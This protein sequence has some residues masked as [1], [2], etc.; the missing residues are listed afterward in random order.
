MLELA[1]V[2]ERAHVSLDLIY[3]LAMLTNFRKYEAKNMY[4]EHLETLSSVRTI[5]Y[6]PP[7]PQPDDIDILLL[8][9][10]SLSVNV[11]LACMGS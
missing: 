5:D 11:A 10:M 8:P 4:Q 9:S 7:H 3:L 6:S 1:E 2:H